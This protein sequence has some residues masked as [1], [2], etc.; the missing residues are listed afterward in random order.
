[1]GTAGA[2]DKYSEAALEIALARSRAAVAIVAAAAIACVAVA[3]STGGPVAARVIAATWAMC[4][5]LE[6][7]HRVA[8]HRGGAGAMRMVLRRPRAIE[9][10]NGAGRWRAGTIADGCFVAPWLTVVRWRPSGAWIDR[11]IVVLPDMMD[12][13]EFRRLRIHLRWA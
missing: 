12:P 7:I 2:E 8:L 11:T 1:M 6:A 10:M 5:A 4:L 9:V 3:V 13:D